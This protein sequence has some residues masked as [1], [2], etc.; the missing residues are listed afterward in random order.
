V[1]KVFI[2]L[3]EIPAQIIEKYRWKRTGDRLFNMVSTGRISLNLRKV[4]ALCGI[5]HLQFHMARHT[6]ATLICIHQGVPMETISKMMGHRTMESTRIYAE[7]TGQ[8]IGEDM[9]KL[10]ARTTG[11]Y[12]IN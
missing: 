1:V 12:A 8:K 6:F 10:A 2:P 9:K 11:K 4:E 3:L 5:G 7:I